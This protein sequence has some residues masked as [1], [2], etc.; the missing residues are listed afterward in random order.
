MPMR[1]RLSRGGASTTPFF[2]MKTLDDEASGRKPSRKR[3]VSVAPAA[4]EIWRASTLPSSDV[5][6]TWHFSQRKSREVTHA[7]PFSTASR[8][9]VVM[10]LLIMNTVG[11]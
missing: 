10:G 8:D 7:T 11:V 2:T 3:M 9:G 1:I 6:F 5:D 4:T